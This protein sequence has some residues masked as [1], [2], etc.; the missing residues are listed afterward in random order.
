[1]RQTR[2]FLDHALM[3][4]SILNTVVHASKHPR[5][6]LDRF[7]MAQLGSDLIEISNVATVIMDG[8][9]KCTACTCRGLF[10]H[11]G[12]IFPSQALILVSGIFVAFELG[13]QIQ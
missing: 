6:I 4:A 2:N 1:M 10:E 13:S 12:N 11:Q 7:L 9:L 5:R 3:I 8:T